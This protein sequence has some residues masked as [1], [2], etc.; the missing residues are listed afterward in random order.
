MLSGFEL[1]VSGQ[2]HSILVTIVPGIEDVGECMVE[3]FEQRVH[4]PVLRRI[5]WAAVFGGLAIALATQLLLSLLGIG[6][7]ASTIHPTSSNGASAQS[8]GNGSVIWFVLTSLIS[9]FAGGWVAGRLAGMPRQADGLLHGLIAWSL[10]S[11]FTVYLLTTAI[12][13]IISG[14]TG[15]LGTVL[16]TAGTG[17]A[18]AAPGAAKTASDQV[19]KSGV[20]TDDVTTKVQQLLRETGNPKL[21][22]DA[23][24]TE[25]RH[26]ANLAK[27]T[28]RENALNPSAT[29][30]NNNE[31]VYRFLH[32]TDTD[33][34]AA[35]RQDLINV[36]AAEQH[37][38]KAQA[39]RTVDAWGQE[40]QQARFR[41]KQAGDQAAAAVAKAALSGFFLFLLGA[42]AA[43]AGGLL[44]VRSIIADAV[45]EEKR[46]VAA[47]GTVIRE[48][49]TRQNV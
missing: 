34:Q 16:G 9:L 1:S 28:A 7:G 25:S 38:T 11:L 6:I 30:Q 10:T 27:G 36:V 47:G 19:A 23:L 41:I 33:S 5:S 15:A 37:I 22:P 13:G 29:Q 14:A 24:Q 48:T 26:Q 21:N 49:R 32:D 18:M 4:Q 42:V 46:V 12:G 3:A 35:D 17:L 20:T 40:A 31:L 43:A 44:S 2:D 8:V 39:A 45:L